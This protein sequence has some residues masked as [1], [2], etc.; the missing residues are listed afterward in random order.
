MNVN[1][2]EKGANT[3]A[4]EM[5]YIS[6]EIT[7]LW[8]SPELTQL[9]EDAQHQKSLSQE[10]QAVIRNMEYLGKYYFK[11]PKEIIVKKTK[12]T[13]EAFMVWQK[14]K[15]ENKFKDFLPYLREIVELNKVIASHLGYK[16]NPYDALLDLFEQNLTTSS[17]KKT[18]D[19]IKPHLVSLTQK[20]KKSKKY[21]DSHDLVNGSLDYPIDDQIKLATFVIKKLNYDLKAGR[22][23]ISTHP[24]TLALDRDDVRITT[25]YSQDDFRE[26]FAAAMHETGHALYEQGINKDYSNTPL[27]EGVSFALHESQ[28]RFWENQVGRNPGFIKFMTPIFQ[29]FFPEQLNEVGFET[30]SLLFNQ[31]R[32][33]LI[34]VEADEVTYILHI[35]IRFELEDALINNRLKVENLPKAWNKKMK[36][37]LGVIPKT[38]REGVLQDVHWSS[39]YFGYFPTYALGNLYAAQFT[40][41]MKKELDFDKL[42]EAGDFGTVLSWL[43]INIHQY[44]R[45]YWPDELIKKVTKEPLNAKYFIDYLKEKYSK[46]YSL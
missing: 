26:S 12:V 29:A 42:L 22:M 23:D 40:S 16:D 21:F 20:I 7:D 18:F 15:K 44:G 24:F 27:E 32:S 8:L 45:V 13:A 41:K 34:R 43:R 28:S 33:S 6:E 31:V 14:A 4:Q 11:V 10:E 19:L 2:P 37:Y 5:A 35:I 38:D 36:K 25:R 17:C 1:L 9:L 30:L 3:R 39:G 46:I